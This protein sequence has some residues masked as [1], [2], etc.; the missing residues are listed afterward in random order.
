MFASKAATVL[1][2]ASLILTTGAIA[3]RGHATASLRVAACAPAWRLVSEGVGGG[4]AADSV[5][6]LSRDDA[7]FA[8]IGLAPT[9]DHDVPW[10]ARWNGRTVETVK[11]VPEPGHFFQEGGPGSFDS[12]T[13]GW[14]VSPQ[15]LFAVDVAERWHGGRWTLTPLAVSPHPATTGVHVLTFG[16]ISAGNAW[17]VGEFYRAAVG[18]IAGSE[19]TGA[20]IEHWDGV[21]WNIVPNP[22]SGR[23]GTL[24]QAI[25]VIS[26]HDIWAAGYQ[27]TAGSTI[28]PLA[29]HWD[30]TR[31][32]AVTIPAG[33]GGGSVI[34]AISASGGSDVWA[35]GAQ[36]QPG[37]SDTAIP[38][39]E[40]WN[41][42]TWQLIG[43][44]PNIGNSVSDAIYAASPA[45]VWAGGIFPLHGSAVFLHWNG[46]SWQSV[47]VPGPPEYGVLRD[48]FGMGGTGPHDVW[49][50]GQAFNDGA[51]TQQTEIDHLSCA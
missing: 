51:G 11:A 14:M 32:R 25:S 6:A 15:L 17:A 20:L 30:G 19:P 38:M 37:T 49:A 34:Y 31:W 43:G 27:T 16:S 12:A 1:A 47:A 22:A 8:G 21:Q 39:V 4:E 40:H 2:G 26:A 9:G 10:A 48:I 35:A 23:P 45:D 18:I 29:E 5:Q 36:I 3:A 13:D 50:V 44:L 28:T 7:M 33:S 46:V 42:T 24:L 41:G